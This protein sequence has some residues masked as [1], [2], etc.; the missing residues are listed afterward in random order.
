MID[1]KKKNY[2]ILPIIAI[3]LMVPLI[4]YCKIDV[5]NYQTYLNWRG[6]KFEMDLFSYYKV[7][8]TIQMTF[9]LGIIYLMSKKKRERLNN[10]KEYKWMF[11]YVICIITSFVLSNYKE[12]ALFGF[13]YRYEGSILLITYILLL[14]MT[15]NLYDHEI[16]SKKIIYSIMIAYTIVAI[17]GISQFFDSDI[18][19]KNFMQ[20]L[21]IPNEQSQLIGT[22][23]GSSKASQK[24]AGLI[25]NANYFAQYFVILAPLFIVIFIYSKDKK[26]KLLSGTMSILGASVIIMSM[27]E[28][29]M[30]LLS[31]ILVAILLLNIKRLINR[32]GNKK[33]FLVTLIISLFFVYD[34]CSKG[35]VFKKISFIVSK[36]EFELNPVHDKKLLQYIKLNNNIANIESKDKNMQI[37]V[38]KDN[39]FVQ[40]EDGENVNLTKEKVFSKDD[41]IIELKKH[42]YTNR[43][44]IHIQIGNNIQFRMIVDSE[45]LKFINDAD[46]IIEQKEIKY[47]FGE[48]KEEFLTGRMYIWSRS[49]PKIMEKPLFGYGADTFELVFPN[50][51]YV[52]L[53]KT[54]NRNR[55]IVDKPHNMYIG[56]AMNTGIIALIAFLLINLIYIKNT[57]SILIKSKINNEIDIY[58]LGILFSIISY[59]II[60]M[61][62]DSNIVSTSIYYILLGIGINLNYKEKYYEEEIILKNK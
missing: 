54:Y 6:N 34:F 23:K 27:S 46:K 52:G 36:I 22:L 32:Y 10:L 26:M 33:I 21:I 16:D 31:L 39:I 55:I 48:G 7:L 2:Y 11:L 47:I 41:I 30:I 3:I 4:V 59:L 43:D 60:G 57:I 19:T 61:M 37:I 56:I 29:A 20:R 17:V 18:V 12:V 13:V 40:Y 24:V 50:Y 35:P 14:Y 51:D 25:G 8:F 5:L 38:K 42:K 9:I 15:I 53:Y 45:K 1:I 49:I 58:R 28:A 44:I 62:Y